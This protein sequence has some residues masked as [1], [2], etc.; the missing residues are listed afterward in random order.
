MLLRLGLNSWIQVIDLP[1]PLEW[2]GLQVH[3]MPGPHVLCYMH[4]L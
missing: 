1:Q 3:T 2:L 4:T